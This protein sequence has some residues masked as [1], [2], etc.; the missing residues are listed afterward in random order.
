MEQFDVAIVGAGPAGSSA[1]YY[2]ANAGFQVILLE[3]GKSPGSKNVF[4]GRIYPY[5]LEELIPNYMEDAP[6]ERIIKKEGLTFMTEDASL[7]ASF[8]A[9]SSDRRFSFT[10]FRSR[11]DE[12]LAQKAVE[13]GAFL[14]NEVKVDD[15]L[16]EKDRIAGIVAGGDEIRTHLVI[17]ADGA[18][19]KIA[20]K[21]GLRGSLEPQNFSI[22]VKEVI[23]LPKGSIND[24]FQLESNEGA[25]IVY[26]GYATRFLRGGGFLYTNRESVSLGI[27]VKGVDLV[28][29]RIN[30]ESLM[31][32][33]KEHEVIRNLIVDG[34]LLEYNTH[35]IP[36]AGFKMMPRLFTDGLILVGDAAGFIINN[37]YTFRGVDLAIASGIAAAE[38]FT[39]LQKDGN[40][41]RSSLSA[42]L[43]NLDKR[44]VIRDLKKF[45]D[46][47]SFLNNP[48][49][50]SE[51]PKIL[52]DLLKTMYSIDGRGGK[53]IREGARETMKGKISMTR[54]VRDLIGGMNAI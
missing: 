2:L 39:Q 5:S 46:G 53:R 26:V 32:N 13:K 3:R 45:K 6:I 43:T 22:G 35:L 50:Y 30:V 37:G 8:S 20:Q 41:N 49:L 29:R 16:V 19:S 54:L 1:A 7:S 42:Y 10:V 17:A 28:E 11:F 15:V 18:I 52:M 34:K 21:A 36:E 38:T 24:R 33:F 40:T 4:G 12:W 31:G 14:L 25:S 47:P 48:R 27:V 44:N 9:P 23:E 51:Y